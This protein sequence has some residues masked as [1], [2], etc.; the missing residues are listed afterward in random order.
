MV[1]GLANLRMLG[2]GLDAATRPAADMVGA[3]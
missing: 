2:A 1:S 3:E